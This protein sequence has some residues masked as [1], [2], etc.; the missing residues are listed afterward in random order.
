MGTLSFEHLHEV[1]GVDVVTL[2]MRWSLAM[3]DK[4]ALSGLTLICFAQ[5]DGAWRLTQDASM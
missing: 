4:P 2:A 3:A 5:R 1:V